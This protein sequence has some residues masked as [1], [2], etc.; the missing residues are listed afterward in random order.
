MLVGSRLRISFFPSGGKLSEEN[1]WI[2][3]AELITWDE[4]KH[5]YAFNFS[6]GIAAPTK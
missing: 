1:N 6:K 5:H 2:K 4:L 3:L